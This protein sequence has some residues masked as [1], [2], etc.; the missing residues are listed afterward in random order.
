MKKK[1][2]KK[3]IKELKLQLKGWVTGTTEGFLGM[4]IDEVNS[5]ERGLEDARAGRL[6]SFDHSEEIEKMCNANGNFAYE[7]VKASNE[8]Y[9]KLSD[10]CDKLKGEIAQLLDQVKALKG[11]LI[12]IHFDK[13]VSSP[14]RR[15][16]WGLQGS[17]LTVEDVR[18]LTDRINN[19]ND[20]SIEKIV[21][22]FFNPFED[23]S[24]KEEADFNNE[25]YRLKKY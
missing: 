6:I 12:D 11:E 15:K 23:I 7:Y 21:N 10:E 3:Q 5:L 13:L 8:D 14:S 18:Q 1:E 16:A 25:Q 2:L 24:L 22:D 20:V 19:R 17:V 9:A 4:P